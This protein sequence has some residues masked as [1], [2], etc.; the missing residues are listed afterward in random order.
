MGG[1]TGLPGN[2]CFPKAL[3][4]TL[5][6]PCYSPLVPY[7]K[8]RRAMAGEGS[9]GL[10]SGSGVTCVALYLSFVSSR[11]PP[12]PPLPAAPCGGDV[13]SVPYAFCRLSGNSL[14]SGN[15]W[16]VRGG[17]LRRAV[18]VLP[19]RSFALSRRDFSPPPL[20]DVSSDNIFTYLASL[21]LRGF[22]LFSFPAS[23]SILPPPAK[24]FSSPLHDSYSPTL[25][26]SSL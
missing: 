26:V 15:V 7:L 12:L 1:K 6:G 14:T 17:G 4:I 25:P 8:H 24:L 5:A 16:G 23:S 9:P 19:P 20:V 18:V 21:Y 10:T 11:R 13:L 3:H 2:S 22:H